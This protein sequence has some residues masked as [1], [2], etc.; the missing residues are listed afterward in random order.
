MSRNF[1]DQRA[2]KRF[3]MPII[4]DP[5]VQRSENEIASNAAL[6]SYWLD[7]VEPSSVVL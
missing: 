2:R 3:Q 4:C 7:Q 5:A 6:R 1:V